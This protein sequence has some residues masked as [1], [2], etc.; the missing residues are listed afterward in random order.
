MTSVAG[1]KAPAPRDLR[2]LL[3]PKSIAIVGASDKNDMSARVFQNL[4]NHG[5]DGPVYLVN[6]NQTT[7]HGHPAV[8]SLD[9]IPEKIDLAFLLVGAPRVPGLLDEFDKHDIRDV[10]VLSGGF[11]EVGEEG[12]DL[13]RQILERAARYQQNVLGPNTIGFLNLH[14]KVVLYGS[15]LDPP[16][17]HGGIVPAG[18]V[19]AVV[20]SG[21]I[22]HSLIRGMHGRQTGL[23]TVVAVGNEANVRVHDVIDHL[24]RDESTTVIALFIEA[25][26][27]HRAFRAACLRA[28][29]AGKPIVALKAARSEVGAI[30]AISH[31][32]A[33]AGDRRITQAAFD[34]LG[35]LSV[36][37]LE[38]MLVTCSYLAHHGAPT[39]TR[40]AFIAISGGFCEMFADRAEEVGI[41]MPPLSADTIEKLRAILPKEATVGNPLD[42]TGI[43]QS[44]PTLFPRVM[45]VMSQEPGLDV[46]FVGRSQWGH[47][48]ASADG[49]VAAYAPWGEVIK[50][51]PI[52]LQMVSDIHAETTDFE[53][54]F[55]RTCQLT[56]EIGGITLGL[57][58]FARAAQWRQRVDHLTR[59]A[60]TGDVDKVRPTAAVESG[61]KL[62]EHQV[63]GV[64]DQA[65]IPVVPRCFA[66]SRDEAIDAA[67]GLGF[68]VVLK[69]SS[70][71]IAHKSAVGGVVLNLSNEQDVGNAWDTMMRNVRAK[72][73]DAAIDGGL[74]M[75]MRT[76]GLEII[77]GVKRDPTWGHALVVGM[78]GVWTE[79]LN[80][81]AVCALPAQKSD[82]E[83]ALLGLRTARLFAGGHG[84]EPT[85]VGQLADVILRICAFAQSL[86]DAFEALEI[87]P[88]KLRGPLIEALDGLIVWSEV[89]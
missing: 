28:A 44:D 14:S 72:L 25:V 39:G 34:Q 17:Y 35:I 38:E 65:G 69:V 80:D 43:A 77:V 57:Q 16:S 85:D 86:P 46:V 21:I 47:R 45:E 60:V 55:S 49:I 74:L 2:R 88:L 87:N 32:G 51:A 79:V 33:L 68:P 29:Q 13:Q 58:A 6:P 71:D 10:V 67:K 15:P 81:T 20:Q 5:F 31:T 19:G 75:P 56:P 12:D 40:A 42:T 9:A 1:A 76:G 83:A 36:S 63:L 64:L 89:P 3:A 26:R 61:R 66:T 70:S 53:A 8:A 82:V 62:S 54:E 73:P 41:V 4:I 7:V 24:V 59:L 27:D 23:S 37:S 30:T 84:I 50:K 11:A 18:P 78:G 22:A 52:P 48:P